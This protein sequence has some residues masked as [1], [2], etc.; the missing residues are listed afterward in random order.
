MPLTTTEVLRKLLKT[1][2]ITV[3]FTKA[4]G[5]DRL[6]NCTLLPSF[7]PSKEEAA[8]VSTCDKDNLELSD[9]LVV[10]D[11]NKKDWRSFKTDSIKDLW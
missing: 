6:M 8:E 10:W 2:I 5:S 3:V 4:D 7:L 9:R 1:K 11:I